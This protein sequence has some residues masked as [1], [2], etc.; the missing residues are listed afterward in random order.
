[1]HSVFV[2]VCCVCV[3]ERVPQSGADAKHAEDVTGKT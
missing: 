1:M 3:S 2:C